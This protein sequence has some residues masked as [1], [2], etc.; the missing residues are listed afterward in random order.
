M[1]RR[2]WFGILGMIGGLF[3]PCVAQAQWTLTPL[4]TPAQ[5]ESGQPF[6]THD[7]AGR[8]YLSWLDR[9][10]DEEYTFR[11]SELNVEAHAW[12][13]PQVIAEGDNWFVNWADVPSL[14]VGAD[15]HVIAHWLQRDGDG[16]YAYGIRARQ[17]FNG[18]ETWT[19]PTWI[20]EDR[21][22]TEHG[23]AALLPGGGGKTWVA[24]LDGRTFTSGTHEMTLRARRLGASGMGG[25]VVLD[26]LT[27][28]C[29]PVDIAALPND[30]ALVVYRNRTEDEMR[31]I[32]AV[33]YHEGKWGEPYAV[34]NDGWQIAGC[35]VNGPSVDTQ[36]EQVVTAWF[37]AAKDKPTIHMAFSED[38]GVH[39][40]TPVAVDDGQPL[41]RVDVVW[42][43]DG[44]AL[45]SWLEKVDTG[46]EVRVKQ[47]DAKGEVRDAF[48]VTQTSSGRASGYPRMIQ[49]GSNAVVFAWRSVTDDHTGVQ[50]I[51]AQL[52]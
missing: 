35:P 48:T 19:A 33:R 38:S 1:K 12:S 52:H 51:L 9:E 37:T 40:S 15:G 29:C 2:P 20:H 6:L 17:S 45:V 4:D 30:G 46:A 14:A 43:A 10:S 44:S 25:E 5:F 13:E 8:V 11:W 49:A 47:V 28:D 31:D 41:G 27:C 23:F 16:T 26:E 50:T 21:S 39:F 24:W 7:V 42:L 3:F 32:W 36:G 22:P 34:S 18:G